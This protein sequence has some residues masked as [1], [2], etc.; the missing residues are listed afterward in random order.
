M[1][2][3]SSDKAAPDDHIAELQRLIQQRRAGPFVDVDEGE[4]ETRAMLKQKRERRI[5]AAGFDHKRP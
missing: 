1:K 3:R 2:I 4:A 5:N